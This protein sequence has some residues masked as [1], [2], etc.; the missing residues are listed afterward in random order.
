M[1]RI[2]EAPVITPYHQALMERRAQK[3][4]ELFL[5]VPLRLLGLIA[6]LGPQATFAFAVL[7][8]V[9]CTSQK[10]AGYFWLRPDFEAAVGRGPRWWHTHTQTLEKAGVIEVERRVGAKPRYRLL[11]Q[12]GRPHDD[13]ATEAR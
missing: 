4:D 3:Q 9:Q 7:Y 8:S 11:K 13:K 2:K 1:T 12:K 5:R 10:A 6:P